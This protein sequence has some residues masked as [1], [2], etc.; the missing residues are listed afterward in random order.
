MNNLIPPSPELD[1]N[2]L[3]PFTRFCCTIGMIPSSY[4]L[5][6]TYEEQLLWLCDYLENTVI[7]TVNNNGEV[8]TELQNLF[9]E[10]KGY[11]DHY[12][13]NLDVQNEINNKLDLMSTDGTLEN[14]INQEI[15]SDMN[16]RITANTNNLLSNN[17]RYK[18][19]GVGDSY[20]IQ[21]FETNPITK[22]YWEYLTD[23]L[24][25]TVNETFFKAYASGASFKNGNFLQAL[26]N[27]ENT[28]TNKN[29]IT[30]ILITGGWND[31]FADITEQMI[32]NAMTSFNTYAKTNY[33]NAR[34]KLGF[35]SY[36][37]PYI[38]GNSNN[39]SLVLKALQAY[40]KGANILGWQ[41]LTGCENILHYFD[42]SYWQSDGVHPSQYGQD[43]LGSYI[44]EAFLNGNV[45]VFRKSVDTGLEMT[46]SGI[47][48]QI[49]SN[50]N[51]FLY[52]QNNNITKIETQQTGG[53][54]FTLDNTTQ[55]NMNGANSYEIANMTNEVWYGWNNRNSN[56][57]PFQIQ[58]MKDGALKT[59]HGLAN[60]FL[61]QGKLHFNPL[62][63]DLETNQAVSGVTG[64]YLFISSLCL[65][66][67]TK[68]C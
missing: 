43:E 16:S 10:L 47:C 14:I 17:V 30:D 18:I 46:A 25:L 59:Y 37:N 36:S 62:C 63:F 53:Q 31:T 65:I 42:T 40:K 48:S 45:D 35:I 21:Q 23:A 1:I 20:G 3:K 5:S 12:F 58:V 66:S 34:I 67:D 50:R 2:K 54:F 24:G 29:E 44:V 49:P 64:R 9:V 6:L 26:R 51:K 38:T 28:I 11:V 27:L 7:P 55:L 33:P 13:D 39:V 60:F 56:I 15:F 68:L 19:I 61:T 22:Y 57:Q 52:S 4:K 41:F 32:I 8:V